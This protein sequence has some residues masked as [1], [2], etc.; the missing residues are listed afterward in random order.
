LEEEDKDCE[1]EKDSESDNNDDDNYE[2]AEQDKDKENEKDD[3]E[4][5]IIICDP[6][7]YDLSPDAPA[8]PTQNTN[9]INNN[10][11]DKNGNLGN[12]AAKDDNITEDGLNNVG[13]N[14]HHFRVTATIF[15]NCHTNYTGKPF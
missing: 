7:A 12:T 2:P 13:L 3:K 9:S 4:F 5:C 14:L 10:N 15:S 8:P 1:E 6:F 11:N